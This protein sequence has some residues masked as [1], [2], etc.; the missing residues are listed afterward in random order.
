MAWHGH[1]VL[2]PPIAGVDRTGV[3]RAR[4]CQ[5]V[6]CTCNHSFVSWAYSTLFSCSDIAD[7]IAFF[8]STPCAVQPWRRQ[9]WS[10]APSQ[11]HSSGAPST[12]VLPSPSPH[13]ALLPSDPQRSSWS[14]VGALLELSVQTMQ[15][16]P[17]R[18]SQH[19]QANTQ[20]QSAHARTCSPA[21]WS[22]CLALQIDVY[23]HVVFPLEATPDFVPNSL[24]QEQMD[25]S[26][27]AQPRL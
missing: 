21:S 20:L 18:P 3:D 8:S 17:S 4:C 26:V 1:A 13:G 19:I 22:D 15:L 16:P 24:I 23:V 25:V 6:V 14:N 2:L 11:Q 9:T 12:A 7:A 5:E 27:Q 10:L